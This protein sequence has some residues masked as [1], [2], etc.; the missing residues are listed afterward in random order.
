MY[1]LN[2]FE[3]GFED[4][5][6]ECFETEEEAQEYMNEINHNIRTGAEVLHMSNPGDYPFDEDEDYDVDYEIVEIND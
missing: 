1:R 3:D 6:N 4:E 5:E 2:I